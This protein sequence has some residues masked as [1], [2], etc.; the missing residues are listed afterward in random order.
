[1]YRIGLQTADRMFGELVA[2]LEAKGALRN[3]LVIVLSDHGEAMGLPSDSFFDE[4]FKVEGLRA[5]LKMEAYGHGQSVLRSPSTR[6]CWGFARTA[7]PEDFGTDG[8]DFKY[9]VTVEDIAPTILEFLGI[10]GDRCRRRGKS[11]LP[12]LKS[13]RDGTAPTLSASASR[14]PIFGCCRGRAVA[15]TRRHRPTELGLLRGRP[16]DRTPAHPARV[17]SA[18]ACIQRTSGFHEGPLACG[19]AGGPLRTSIHFP[20]FPK[21][22]GRLLMARPSDDESGRAA[23]VGRN[24]RTLQG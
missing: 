18:G 11:L 4:T 13:G 14:K 10:G 3:A 6:S 1:M 5:P 8:R 20:R 15:W 23:P 16:R 19:H 7:A 21:K 9:P 22:H 12:M 24:G 17:R 2:M